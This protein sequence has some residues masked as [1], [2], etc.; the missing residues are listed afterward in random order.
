M[1]KKQK[2]ITR[3]KLSRSEEEDKLYL[4]F[5]RRRIIAIWISFFLLFAASDIIRALYHEGVHEAIYSQAGID[6][7]MGWNFD[8]WFNVRFYVEANNKTLALERCGVMCASLQE[9]NELFTY[10]ISAIFYSMWLIAGLYLA[11]KHW[12]DN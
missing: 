7:H 3:S 8:K 4:K 12:L 2:I 9:E 6:S 10:N 11:N 5:R 1:M